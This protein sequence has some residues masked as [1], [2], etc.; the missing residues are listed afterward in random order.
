MT[1]K[2][3]RIWGIL[4]W[5]I[6]IPE[7]FMI[8]LAG[9]AKFMSPTTWQG[10]F[11]EWGYPIWFTSVI[12]GTEIVFALLLLAPRLAF[13][14]GSVLTVVMIGALATVVIHNSQLG[15]VMPVIHLTLL[16]LIMWG[17]FGLRWKQD[18]ET[19]K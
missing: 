7:V 16:S 5:V 9:S 6:T 10:M 15:P 13:Y 2:T 18:S 8:G 17:R 4:L 14:A 11:V 1:N 19:V 3:N 12:G